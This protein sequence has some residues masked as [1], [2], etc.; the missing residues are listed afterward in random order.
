MAKIPNMAMIKAN[1]RLIIMVKGCFTKILEL[2]DMA[3]KADCFSKIIK[4]IEK[5]NSNA[6]N[7][8]M[9]L[10][11]RGRLIYTNSKPIIFE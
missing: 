3:L 11:I 6:I 10:P 7:I 5:I 9:I 8:C 2:F 4:G 1:A